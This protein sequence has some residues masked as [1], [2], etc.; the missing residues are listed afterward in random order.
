MYMADEAFNNGIK[1][2]A[3]G[4]EIGNRVLSIVGGTVGGL[5]GAGL[6]YLSGMKQLELSEDV[7]VKKN[8]KIGN[9]Y[10]ELALDKCVISKQES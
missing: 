3:R 8:L 2:A 5:I 10:K 9:I 7:A 6:S 1:T 4:A